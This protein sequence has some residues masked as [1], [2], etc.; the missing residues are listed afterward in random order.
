VAV[1]R[2]LRW[3]IIG[4]VFLATLINFIDRLTVSI[5]GPVIMSQLQLTNTQFGSITAW[6]LV[7]YTVSQGFSGKLYDHVG[8]KRGFTVSVL[9]W[10]IAASCMQFARGLTD[11]RV[12]RVILGLGEAG[13]WPGAAK[14][15]AEWFPV[16]ERAFAMGIFNSGVAVG[17]IVAFPLVTWLQWRFGWKTTFVVTGSL[18]FGWLLL[19][20]WLYD[21]PERHARLSP[22]ELSLIREGAPSPLPEFRG[23]GSSNI[24]RRGRSCS[25]DF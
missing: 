24:D 7:A 1:V 3:W 21:A 5:L 9:V 22:F 15:I 17:N 19:W 12:L 25:R 11:L 8:V 6:F 20:L 2:G 18:G 14:V 4:L 16:R 10:S 23:A 13:N